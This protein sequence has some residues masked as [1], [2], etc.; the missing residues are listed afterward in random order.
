MKPMSIRE[1]RR[2]QIFPRLSEHQLALVEAYGHRRRYP[3]GA[4]LYQEGQRHV[5]MFVVLSGVVDIVRR[6]P[7][8]EETIVTDGPGTFT[9]EVGQLAGRGVIA[10]GRVREDTE[11]LVIEEADLRRLVVADADL[12]ELIM[13][14][15]ILRRVALIEDAAARTTVIG[16]RGSPDTL[17]LRQFL[18]R[19]G[20]PHA[21]LDVD[22]DPDT[23][24]VLA[25]FGVG[26]DELPVVLLF[27]G[28]LLRSPSNREIA[29]A[30]GISPDRLDG[31]TFDLAVVG[32]GPAGLAAAVYAASEGLGVVVFDGKAPGGQAGTTSRIENY[33]GFPTGIS[34]Q[35]LAG[36]G[37]VQA[38][39]FGA[40]VAVPREVQRLRCAEKDGIFL[41]LDGGERVTARTVVVASGARYRKPA[42]ENLERFEGRGVYYAAAF[43]E[44][45]FCTGQEVIVVGGG[46][47]AGQAA[48]F[49]AGHV[50]HV[51]VLV[52][53][54]GLAASMSNYLIQRIDAT[55]NIT[56]RTE[57]EIVELIGDGALERVRWR[58]GAD[59]EERPIEHVFLFL[60]AA[61]NTEWINSC[62]ALD[63]A[64]FVKTGTDISAEELRASAWPLERP[65]HRLET[66]RPGIF[67]VGDVRS[68]SVKRV[69]AAVGEGSTAV[70]LVHLALG[71][72]R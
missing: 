26:P 45:Q 32:A 18:T 67:A 30:I 39:K 16:G 7:T 46:N 69:A 41:E 65:P 63:A 8:G 49:L 38:Q 62:L 34:G 70:Q 33:F 21:Y 24:A 12:S 17:R 50:R 36:R 3:A 10:T 29:D 54:S 22:R 55:P 43:M 71:E 44:A 68:G 23:A 37:F 51:H 6:T 56:L 47:S 25:R 57:T 14:A 61:P 1:T 35:A 11:V 66:S 60:G 72:A 28:R 58:H 19:N 15:F 59:V 64:G 5:P 2:E 40:E 42:L 9:G 20:Q 48:V 52:R 13:R 27:D 31:R 4:I 53:S